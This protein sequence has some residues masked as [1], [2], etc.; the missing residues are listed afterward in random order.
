MS[1]LQQLQAKSYKCNGMVVQ[2]G[3]LA[4]LSLFSVMLLDKVHALKSGIQFVSH[5]SMGGTIILSALFAQSYIF[6]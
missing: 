3:P 1:S 5:N 4:C 6:A 2:T